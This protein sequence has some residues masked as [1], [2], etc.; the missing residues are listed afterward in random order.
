MGGVLSKLME[1]NRRMGRWTE[2][3]LWSGGEKER[4]GVFLKK[5]VYKMVEGYLDIRLGNAEGMKKVAGGKREV[6]DGEWF[7][8]LSGIDRFDDF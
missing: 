3:V 5:G 4:G 6:W 7:G 8:F 1:R 2:E